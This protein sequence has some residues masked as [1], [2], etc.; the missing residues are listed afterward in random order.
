MEE[1][2]PLR[3]DAEGNWFEG[4]EEILH[5]RLRLHLFS[6]LRRDPIRGYVVRS[7]GY[8]REVKVADVPFVVLRTTPRPGVGGTPAEYS[9]L[10]SDLTEERL[11]PETLHWGRGNRLYCSIRKGTFRARFSRPAYLQL[12]WN[13]EEDS[14]S[15]R[16]YLPWAEGRYYF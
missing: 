3:I 10:L 16:L 1:A 7:G 11:E 14:D 6:L 8:T 4:T 5:E 12:A 13:L 9:L 2:P 15:G